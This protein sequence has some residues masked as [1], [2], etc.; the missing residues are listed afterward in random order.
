MRAS[1]GLTE[2]VRIQDRV[3]VSLLRE[4]A[5]PVL[6]EVLIDGV[7]RDEGVKVGLQARLLRPQQAAEAL[8]LFLA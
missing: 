6:R 4:K 2:R 7:A 8:S 1:G 3:G 5:L